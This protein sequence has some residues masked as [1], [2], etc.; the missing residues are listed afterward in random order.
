MNVRKVFCLTALLACALGASTSASAGWEAISLQPTGSTSYSS[1]SGVSGGQQAGYIGSHAALWNGTANGSVDLNPAGY[2]YSN[3]SDMASGSQV[4]DVSSSSGTHA[5]L[6]RGTAGSF[7]DLHPGGNLA[8]FAYGCSATQQVGVQDYEYYTYQGLQA[9]YHACMWTGTAASFL[10]LHPSVAT[11]SSYAYD[12]Y[13]NQQVG[14]TEVGT[15]HATHACMWT[16]TAQSWV[17]LNPAN[18]TYSNAYDVYAGQQVGSATIGGHT[19]AGMWS[20][21]AASWTDLHPLGYTESVL[22]GISAGRQ[23]GRVFI[24]STPHAGIWSG[25]AGSFVDLHNLLGTAYTESSA[26]AVDIVG[27]NVWVAGT[28]KSAATG[29]SE[30]MMWHFAPAVPEPSSLLALGSGLLALAG[31]IRRRK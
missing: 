3:I 14:N 31:V 21:T 6:W 25:T 4:G 22:F 20:G 28:A 12:C 18:S 7:V 2:T 9:E 10:N 8:T 17:D 15:S 30:A 29:R 19:H 23:V 27:D 26:Y 5:A 1:A 13:G 24:G 16:G 11:G